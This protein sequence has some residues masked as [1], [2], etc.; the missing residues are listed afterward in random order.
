MAVKPA[1]RTFAG[2]HLRDIDASLSRRGITTWRTL[3]FSPLW[4]RLDVMRSRHGSLLGTKILVKARV[5]TLK[6]VFALVIVV[7][8]C[9]MIYSGIMGKI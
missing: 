8:G 2:G 4:I 7:L 3:M 5:T 6:S 9:E 1:I